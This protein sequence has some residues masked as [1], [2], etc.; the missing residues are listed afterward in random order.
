MYIILWEYQVKPQKQAEF[1]RMYAANGAWADLFRNADGY[2][3]TEL[4]QDETQATRFMTIDRWD[5]KENFEA[6]Q[7]RWQ[8]EYKALDA[9]CEDLTESESLLGCWESV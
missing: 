9:Q 4:I 2:I 6:F 7:T 8:T 5:S 1:K 3:V